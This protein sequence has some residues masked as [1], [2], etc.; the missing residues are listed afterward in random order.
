MI[1]DTLE[2]PEIVVIAVLVL[3]AMILIY[4]FLVRDKARRYGG[5][6]RYGFFIERWP[7]EDSDI[8]KT[9]PNKREWPTEVKDKSE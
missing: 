4:K 7:Y 5:T 9:W 6:T 8:P 1:A 2:F 3:V